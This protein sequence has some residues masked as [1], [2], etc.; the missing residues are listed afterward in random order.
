MKDK[1][2][3]A[4]LEDVGYD[5]RSYSGRGMMG[6]QCVAVIT[7]DSLPNLIVRTL[8]CAVHSSNLE[9]DDKEFNELCKTLRQT[10]QDNMGRD[11][12]VYYWPDVEWENEEED[13][14]E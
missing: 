14:E 9:E 6:R 5:C 13:D 8:Q 7:E 10:R 12:V 1:R 3:I 2:L 4:Y 11:D